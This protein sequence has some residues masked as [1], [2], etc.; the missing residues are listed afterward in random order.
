MWA[1]WD[2]HKDHKFVR[3][4]RNLTSLFPTSKFNKIL[5]ILA[6]Y[7]GKT[8][9][10]PNHLSTYIISNFKKKKKNNKQK[11]KKKTKKKKKKKKKK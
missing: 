3:L 6:K 8:N 1:F 5:R 10:H 9:S 4:T 11:K 2:L 7:E